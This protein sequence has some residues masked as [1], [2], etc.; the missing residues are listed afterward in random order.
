MKSASP[1]IVST[2]ACVNPLV[3]VF[4]GWDLAGEVVTLRTVVAALVI[5]SSVG[6]I[7]SSRAGARRRQAL[8]EKEGPA[9]ASPLAAETESCRP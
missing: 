6:L 9:L 8:D 4:L 1:A 5:V 3:A 7:V 2:Y